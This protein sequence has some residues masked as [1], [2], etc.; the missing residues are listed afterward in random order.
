MLLTIAFCS[1]FKDLYCLHVLIQTV[2]FSFPFL[3]DIQ[4]AYKRLRRL[5]MDYL[6]IGLSSPQASDTGDPT[7]EATRGDTDQNLTTQLGTR[8]WS[9]PSMTDTMSQSF[10]RTRGVQSPIIGG[11][12]IV[13]SPLLHLLMDLVSLVG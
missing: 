12:G 13:V 9:R 6:G 3:D 11:R 2:K 1:S 7:M 8:T 10:Q 4:E 5:V